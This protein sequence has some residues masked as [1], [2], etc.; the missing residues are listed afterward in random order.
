MNAHELPPTETAASLIAELWPPFD[1][2]TT[3]ERETLIARQ[4]RELQAEPI[5]VLFATARGQFTDTAEA[6][7]QGNLRP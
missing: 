5:P 4:Q 6:L 2:R 1:D 3:D 7:K